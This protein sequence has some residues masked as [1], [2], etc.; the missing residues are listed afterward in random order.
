MA[1]FL[2][3]QNFESV[4]NMIKIARTDCTYIDCDDDA[5]HVDISITTTKSI[6]Q[7]PWNPYGR[8]LTKIWTIAMHPSPLYSCALLSDGIWIEGKFVSLV[9]ILVLNKWLLENCKSI[10]VLLSIWFTLFM[11]K[12]CLRKCPIYQPD[13]TVINRFGIVAR[14]KENDDLV[15]MTSDFFLLKWNNILNQLW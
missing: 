7:T 2:L 10:C 11:E 12:K 4:M 15:M 13:L 1:S 8:F 9:F 14:M 5:N 6:Q 3:E